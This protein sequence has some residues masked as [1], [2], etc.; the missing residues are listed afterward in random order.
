MDYRK[1]YEELSRALWNYDK[2]H[3]DACV[4]LMLAMREIDNKVGEGAPSVSLTL[5]QPPKPE[6]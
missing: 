1:A 2:T 5:L 3:N 4:R 6:E